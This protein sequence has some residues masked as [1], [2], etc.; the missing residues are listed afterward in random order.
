M[1]ARLILNTVLQNHYLPLLGKFF[2][3]GTRGQRALASENRKSSN[4]DMTALCV[5]KSWR[6]G[7]VL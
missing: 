5:F 6:L 7:E 4:P 3:S 1:A 2:L